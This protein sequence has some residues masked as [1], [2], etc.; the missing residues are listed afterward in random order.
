MEYTN[1][2]QV[3]VGDVTIGMRG[4][5]FSYIFSGTRIGMESLVRD[6]KEW[7]YRAPAPT[8]GGR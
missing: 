6:G 8:F 1:K 4:E 7:L 2:L 5:N 3:I